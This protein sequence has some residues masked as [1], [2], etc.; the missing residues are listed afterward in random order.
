MALLDF[1]H[2]HRETN[3]SL[4]NWFNHTTGLGQNVTADGTGPFNYGRSWAAV[5]VGTSTGRVLAFT[6]VTEIWINLHVHR[7]T[8][9]TG[10]LFMLMN[11]STDQCGLRRTAAGA[12]EIIR[13]GTLVATVPSFLLPAL[14]W[15]F[16]QVRFLVS[17]TTLGQAE[18]W[19]NN[20]QVYSGTGLNL[21]N[22][23]TDAIDGWRVSG[24]SPEDRIANVVLYSPTGAVPNARTPETRIY[25]ELPNA[26]GAASAWTRNGGA[27]NFDRVNE[28]PSNADTSF[29]SAAA[30]A[31]DD[32]YACPS[33]I[34]AGSIVYG[35]ANE[36]VVRKD[37][38][39]PDEVQCLIHSGATTFA[40]GI[41]KPLSTTYQRFRHLWTTDPATGLAWT[42]G[43]ANAAQVGIRRT[44]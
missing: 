27:A 1:E 43:N 35:V 34:P 38:A 19:V 28:Q 10:T 20:V 14:A 11:S 17:G 26:A 42:V 9:S 33:S 18:V 37:D 32:L 8:N 39:G 12:L 15:H 31:L 21:R 25:A 7:A 30:A 36:M 23:A 40:D 5:N 2:W 24:S 13:G 4:P 29:N 44:L 41:S 16:V 22:A 6:A 3:L